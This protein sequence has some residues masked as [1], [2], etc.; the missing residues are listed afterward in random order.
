MTFHFGG[1]LFINPLA[2]VNIMYNVIL[3][4]NNNIQLMTFHKMDTVIYQPRGRDVHRSQGVD[5]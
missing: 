4:L 5:K 1:H 3:N 2:S